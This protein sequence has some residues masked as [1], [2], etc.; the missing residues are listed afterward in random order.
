VGRRSLPEDLR[1][2]EGLGARVK[3]GTAF[4]GRTGVRTN[5]TIELGVD[6]HMPNYETHFKEYAAAYERSL[7]QS[8]D[9]K[10]IRAFF[11]EGF[12][13]ASTVGEVKAGANDQTFERALQQGYA[14]YKSIG[15]KHMEVQRVEVEPLY[16]G[17]DKARVFYRAE[18]EKKDGTTLT[19]SFD[20]MYLLQ[21]RQAGPK[22]F[23]FVTGDEMAIYEKH[24]LVD[25]ER[26]PT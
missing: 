10:A 3:S 2:M 16:E 13:A 26:K 22:I 12:V 15:T 24:G 21:R 19:I 25:K 11:A 4:A 20:V 8:V 5:F 18:Y 1:S 17:H 14:F 23:A 6:M 7:G 9:S